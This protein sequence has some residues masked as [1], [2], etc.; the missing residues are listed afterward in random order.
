M[1]S[2]IRTELELSVFYN[3]EEE[4]QI[5]NNLLI[6][7]FYDYFKNEY[8]NLLD[9]NSWNYY[10][11]KKHLTNNACEA[12]HNQLNIIIGMKKPHLWFSVN[13]IKS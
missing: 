10:K 7:Q 2:F 9:Y 1:L 5:L 4:A 13:I 12:Y 3:L 6:N 8:I 11:E